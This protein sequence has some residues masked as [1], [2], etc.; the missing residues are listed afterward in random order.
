MLSNALIPNFKTKQQSH[1]LWRFVARSEQKKMHREPEKKR[2]RR[3]GGGV[4]GGG[5]GKGGEKLRSWKEV[6]FPPTPKASQS[7]QLAGCL[8]RGSFLEFGGGVF[9]RSSSRSLFVW[10]F[11]QTQQSRVLTAKRAQES[12][13][14]NMAWSALA[15]NYVGVVPCTHW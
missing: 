2:R 11:N 10:R 6:G 3:W 8:L 9:E 13:H 1:C 7:F 15:D 12:E 5:G 4:G 14:V